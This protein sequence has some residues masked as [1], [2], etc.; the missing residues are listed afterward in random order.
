MAFHRSSRDPIPMHFLERTCHLVSF[1]M[2]LFYFY[3]KEW[4]REIGRKINLRSQDL[5][6]FKRRQY[7]C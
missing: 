6:F 4:T 2:L 5:I 1:P 7:L 3:R